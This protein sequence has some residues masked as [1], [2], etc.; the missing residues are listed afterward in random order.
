MAISCAKRGRIRRLRNRMDPLEMKGNLE[1]VQCGAFE[2][3]I[4][5]N[6]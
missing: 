1:G 2:Q 6:E 3:L 4:T 5:E